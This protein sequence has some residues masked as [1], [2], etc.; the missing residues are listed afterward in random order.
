MVDFSSASVDRV[1]SRSPSTGVVVA[2]GVVA[3]DD[4]RLDLGGGPL[5]RLLAL[6]SCSGSGN[7][8]AARMGSD[9]LPATLPGGPFGRSADGGGGICLMTQGRDENEMRTSQDL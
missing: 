8:E 1:A 2:S 6:S 7:G 4:G 5:G 3:L 9:F